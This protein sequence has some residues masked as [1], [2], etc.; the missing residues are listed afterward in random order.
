MIVDTSA[1]AAIALGEPRWREMREAVLATSC[2]VPASVLTEL[3]LALAKRG[4][5]II[6]GVAALIEELENLGMQ[7]AP[8]ERHHAAITAVA[9][10][11][12]GKGNGRGGQLN[13]GDLMVYA[14][15][16]DRNVPLL[17]TGRDFASTDL[18]IHP[19]SRL[20]P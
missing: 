2:V 13:F 10:D 14:V 6:A 9:R 11:R 7:V 20:E 19:A 12:F 16:K 3:Q 5:A 17:C 1:L 15:A 18:E 4:E 8:F